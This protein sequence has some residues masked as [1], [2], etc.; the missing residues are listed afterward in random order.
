MASSLAITNEFPSQCTLLYLA[1]NFVALQ[2]FS[3]VALREVEILVFGAQ[4]S[5]L[6]RYK[7]LTI[8][9]PPTIFYFAF[10]FGSE[11]KFGVLGVVYT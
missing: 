4:V 8:K 3:F 2:V 9:R 10:N 5:S 1:G 7:D 6:F 11:G